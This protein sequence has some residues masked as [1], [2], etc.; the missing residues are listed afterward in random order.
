MTKIITK[1]SGDGAYPNYPLRNN[2]GL[3]EDD[4]IQV[5][6]DGTNIIAIEKADALQNPLPS[7]VTSAPKYI[8]AETNYD[9]A[10]RSRNAITPIKTTAI[11]VSRSMLGMNLGYNYSD[12]DFSKAGFVRLMDCGTQWKH[13]EQT[14]GGRDATAVAR[15]DDIISR[16]VASGCE[17]IYVVNDT[18]PVRSRYPTAANPNYWLPGTA[19]TPG[20]VDFTALTAFINWL[21]A[22]YGNK[23][24]Y[25]EGWNEPNLTNSYADANGA[26]GIKD[27][28]NAIYAAV[29]T[30]NTANSGAIK[31]IGPTCTGYSGISTD[32]VSLSSL[33]TAGAYANTT[34]LGY[35]VYRGGGATSNSVG[36]SV[37]KHLIW[38]INAQLTTSSLTSKNLF[39]TE[40][41]TSEFLRVGNKTWLLRHIIYW[42]CRGATKVSPYA[43]DNQGIGDMRISNLGSAWYA[44][45][46]FLVGKTIDWCNELPSGELAVSINGVPQYI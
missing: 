46:S 22:R 20:T 23:I 24:S 29:N 8:P 3:F 35:H 41:G 10:G 15:L 39:I 38:P 45:Y 36:F 25:I 30:W 43:W 27:Y 7:V 16:A 31:V 18:P 2:S 12:F 6:D 33:A 42:L 26:A 11:T 9:T 17:V 34:A 32:T 4:V 21:L 5:Y 28:T 37:P 19:G 44:A 1:L 14:V 40:F 13:I